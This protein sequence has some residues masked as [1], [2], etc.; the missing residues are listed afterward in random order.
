MNAPPTG[1]AL[2]KVTARMTKKTD[3]SA[4][5]S[6]EDLRREIDAIDE[7]LHDLLMRRAEI[8]QEVGLVKKGT[9]GFL[10][11]ARE[12][13]ILRKRA[14]QHKGPLALAAVIRIWRELLA[15]MTLI[16]GKFSVAVHLPDGDGAYW[17]LARD[18]FGVQAQTVA[19]LSPGAVLRVVA[20]DASTVG[21]LPWPM[22]GERDPW[23]RHLC[24]G[25][26]KLPKIIGR[27][28]GLNQPSARS[29]LVVGQVA[30]DPSGDDRTFLAIET[31]EE[32]SRTRLLSRLGKAGFDVEFITDHNDAQVPLPVWSLIE[33]EGFVA[34][35][36]PRI[37][38]LINES[39]G[40]IGHVSIVGAYPV[41][42]ALKKK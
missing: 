39:A 13:Q 16:Q 30:L 20:D 15:S 38:T 4:P 24:T 34:A 18:H 36:D 9:G 26:D 31:L 32:M 42:L 35:D 11:P 8:V 10:R 37:R 12:A 27:L 21:V 3:T 23:W 1:L 25:D 2:H 14:E 7:Q 19:H 41:P 33:V 28:P 29:A 40:E 17:D 6:L 22:D 5:A